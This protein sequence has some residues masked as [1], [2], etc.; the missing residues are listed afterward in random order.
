MTKAP[1]VD[2]EQAA[3]M[4]SPKSSKISG[5]REKTASKSVVSTIVTPGIAIKSASIDL[6]DSFG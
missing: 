6:M 5:Q 3:T 1:F 4:A 2:W